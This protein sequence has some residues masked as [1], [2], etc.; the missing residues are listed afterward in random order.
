MFLLI[1]A[2]YIPV[3]TVSKPQR[4]QFAFVTHFFLLGT[5]LQEDGI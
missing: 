3:Y 4:L 2:T 5:K 1:F